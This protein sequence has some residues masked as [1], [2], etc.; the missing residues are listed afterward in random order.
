[1]RIRHL[2]ERSLRLSFPILLSFTIDDPHIRSHAPML[3]TQLQIRAFPCAQSLLVL[4]VFWLAKVREEGFRDLERGVDDIT[5][6]KRV[7]RTANSEEVVGLKVCWD[8]RID[9]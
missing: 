1:M 6:L 9:R 5:P 3:S 7:V 2:H 8:W 4:R